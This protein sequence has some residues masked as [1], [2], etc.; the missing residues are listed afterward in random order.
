MSLPRE[1]SLPKDGI[2]RIKPLRELE[3]LR[4]NPVCEKDSVVESGATNRLK[5]IAGDT[6]EIMAT[7]KQGDA[8][9]Y[10]V[11]VLCDKENDQWARSCG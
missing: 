9:R 4:Y 3:Q 1:L 7:I 5:N 8:R 6:I 11:R 2:L 10:G